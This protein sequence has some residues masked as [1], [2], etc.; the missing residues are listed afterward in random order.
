[1]RHVE[2]FYQRMVAEKR[3]DVFVKK[4]Q[5]K[6]TKNGE[7][8]QLIDLNNIRNK[9]VREVGAEW[10]SFQAICQ[11]NIVPPWMERRSG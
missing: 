6:S 5:N 9:D 11:L 7:D 10:L 3:I 8:L 4:Q 2:A 1:M